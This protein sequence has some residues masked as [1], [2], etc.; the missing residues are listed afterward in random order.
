MKPVRVLLLLL[1][2]VVVAGAVLVT[3]ALTPSVQRWAVLRA[4]RDLPGLKFEVARLSAG[5]SGVELEGAKLVHRGIPI[6]LERVEADFSPFAFLF[7]ERL[8]LRRLR[9]TGLKVD[10]SRVAPGRAE[11][12]AAAAPA[13]A[14]G[15]LARVTLPFDLEL[16]DVQIDGQAMLPGAPGQPAREASYTISGG[17]IAAG[18][19]GTLR[20]DATLRNTAADAKV[21]ALRAQAELKLTLT[22]RRTF[23]QVGLSTVVTAEGT[24]LAG[25]SQLKANAELYG[26]TVG[27]NYEVAVSTLMNNRAEN[28]LIV[29]AQ[30]P[31]GTQRYTGEWALQART[32]QLEPFS[33]IGVLP[34][35]EASGDGR[36]SLDA[37]T[38]SVTAEGGLRARISR[39]EAIQPAW[40]P[41]GPLTLEADFDLHQQDGTLDLHRFKARLDGAA[42]VLHVESTAPLRYDMRKA[43]LASGGLGSEVLLRADVLGLPVEWVR[44]FIRPADISGGKLTGKVELA[45]SAEAGGLL[46]RSQLQLDELNVAQE[47]RAWLSKAVLTSHAEATVGGNAIKAPKVQVSVQ[48]PAGDRMDLEGSAEVTMGPTPVVALTAKVAA[49]SARSLERWFPGGPVAFQAALDSTLRGD[50]LEVRPGRASLTQGTGKPVLEVELRQPFAFNLTSRTLTPRDADQPVAHIALGRLPL[51]PLPLTQ[52]GATLGGFVEEGQLELA[53]PAG[54][55]VVRA[56]QP[57]RLVDV[58]LTQNRQPALRGLVLRAQPYLEYAGPDSLK[59]QSGEV[60]VSVGPAPLLTLKLDASQS[61]GHDLQAVLGFNLEVPALATQPIFAGAEAVSAGRATGEV[62]ASVGDQA[63]LEARLT[64]NG[65]VPADSDRTLPVANI[66]F[67]AHVQ[68]NGAVSAQVPVLLD[69]AG[70]RSDLEFAL[71]LTPLGRGYSIDGSLTG[72]QVE[73]ED[74]LGMM[75]VFMAPAAPDSADQPAPAASVAPHT[76]SAWSRFSGRLALDVKSVTRGKNWAMTGLTGSVAIEPSLVTLQKLQASFSET[77]HLAA[78]MELRFTGGAMPYRLTGDYS[79]NEFDTGRLFRAIE[80]EKAPTVEGLFTVNG[81]F[82]GNGETPVRALERVHGEVQLTSRQGVFRGLQRTTSKLSMTTKAVE[83]GASVLGSLFGSEKATKTAEKVAGQ[84]YFVDQLAQALGEFNYDLLSVRLTR[85]EL[86]NMNLQDISLVSPEIRLN[87]RGSVSYVVGSPLLEQPLNLSL[88]IAAR[89]KVEQ[90]LG[91]L[92]LLDATKDE[93]G[94]RRSKEPVI[95]GGTLAKPDPSAFFTKMATARI[96]DFL[97]AEN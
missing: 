1:G 13:A 94:Y 54:R 26:T 80:P 95:L 62:R 55:L 56:P 25:A 45:R 74:L 96:A 10:A 53:A 42:P 33:F 32:A 93:L 91:R 43:E 78:K 29:R 40:R 67:R 38:A 48:T 68:A 16:G 2:L 70:N 6:S 87:G 44:P 90:L 5:F 58:S 17:H 15:L 61:P 39:L 52:P 41:F 88:Q 77:S 9:V 69:N 23:G 71:Q 65:L 76:V 34:D 28:L 89:G 3:L 81:K 37:A 97:D 66:G 46:V 79:L 85:D 24:A 83:L 57:L 30:L 27:E 11:T 51:A 59:F 50:T 7:R 22:P 75:G 64:L 8:D 36:F 72:H 92:R 19:E 47:G 49:T 21:S 63:Q 35:F 73:L 86:L 4:T 31:T 60:V 82:S 12:A 84:A 14:P 18:R 20:L